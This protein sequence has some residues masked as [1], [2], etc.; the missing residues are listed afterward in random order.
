M[1]TRQRKAAHDHL[2]AGATPQASPFAG[3]I[4]NLSQDEFKKRFNAWLLAHEK[5]KPFHELRELADRIKKG[6]M[7]L[8]AAEQRGVSP[9]DAAYK[10]AVAKLE[11]LKARQAE[12]TMTAQI[13]FFGWNTGHNVL[14]MS[15]GWNLPTGSYYE[16]HVP[17]VFSVRV[18]LA[19]N[20]I[21]F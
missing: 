15:R 19:E 16:M 9:D 21:P 17:G 20:E 5:D 13:P 3:N 8:R 14:R 4:P 18:D 10:A 12:L 7:K 2:A 6:D 1:A 11:E